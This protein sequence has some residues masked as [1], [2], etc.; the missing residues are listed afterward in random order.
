MPLHTPF[1]PELTFFTEFYKAY[2]STE[3]EPFAMWYSVKEIGERRSSPGHS[4]NV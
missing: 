1:P 2:V 3:G 4:W